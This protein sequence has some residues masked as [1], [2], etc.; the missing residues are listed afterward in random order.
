MQIQK[1][2]W[3]FETPF[4]L[5]ALARQYTKLDEIFNGF[6]WTSGLG[7]APAQYPI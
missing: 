4:Q 7:Q 2:D 1:F 6:L 5:A 3:K